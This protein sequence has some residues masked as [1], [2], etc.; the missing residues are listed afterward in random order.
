MAH[1]LLALD[2]VVLGTRGGLLEDAGDVVAGAP[3]KRAQIAFLAFARL[4]IGADAA[5]DGDV[6]QLNPLRGPTA[7]LGSR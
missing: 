1:H 7:A 4:V 6:S 2:A 5:I 3:G